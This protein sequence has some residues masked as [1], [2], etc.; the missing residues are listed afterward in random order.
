MKITKIRK[1][2]N[3]RKSKKSINNQHGG[4][5]YQQYKSI[6]K[7]CMKQSF[8]EER[9]QKKRKQVEAWGHSGDEDYNN[10]MYNFKHACKEKYIKE[11]G[12]PPSR[13]FLSRF[14]F[15]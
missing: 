11:Y 15:K 8:A 2:K 4:M 10:C 13:P 6:V 14:G 1:R 9:C 3:I 5:T 12:Q 7:D